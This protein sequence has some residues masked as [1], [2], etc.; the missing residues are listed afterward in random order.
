MTFLDLLRLQGGHPSYLPSV[1]QKEVIAVSRVS[2][3]YVRCVATFD[4]EECAAVEAEVGQ[5]FWRVCLIP[6]IMPARAVW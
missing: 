2:C 1:E 4:R 6:G 5:V 3:G